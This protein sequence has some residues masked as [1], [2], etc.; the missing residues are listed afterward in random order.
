MSWENVTQTAMRELFGDRVML[1]VPLARYTS[2]RVGGCVDAMI[3]VKS[4]AEL[5]E[6]VTKMWMRGI[7]FVL[8]GGGS[9]VLIS[10]KGIRGV[11]IHNR[12]RRMRFD[13]TSDP[14][15]VWAE[16]GANLGLIARKAAQYGFSGLEWAVS[17]PG[18][19]GGA[20]VGNAGAHGKDIAG[21]LIVAEILHRNCLDG[22][23]ASKAINSWCIEKWSVDR[24][25]FGYRTSVLKRKI[26]EGVVLSADLRL[27]A[28]TPE[29]VQERTEEFRAYRKC[30][31][32]VGASVGSMFKNP[33][34]DYAGRLIEAAGLKGTSIGGAEIS[35]IHANFFVNRGDA[36]ADDIRK[37]IDLVKSEV[38]KKFGINLELE[39][40]LLGEW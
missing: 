23:P 36:T 13:L 7:P 29:R 15:K 5:L 1:D 9:N 10:D 6:V 11:V 19:L 39:I 22:F 24:F 28:S 35:P 12:A 14:P 8:L 33:S 3:V 17:I 27:E 2:A 38:A 4:R 37:L 21:S 20:I 30:T 26:Y 31:Q 16:S 25:E 34:G 32:P 18:T 40:E